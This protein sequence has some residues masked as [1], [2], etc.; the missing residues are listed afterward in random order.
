MNVTETVT[1]QITINDEEEGQRLRDFLQ[2]FAPSETRELMIKYERDR[3]NDLENKADNL[4]GTLHQLATLAE[5]VGAMG[6]PSPEDLS[7]LHQ[8]ACVAHNAVKKYDVSPHKA[9]PF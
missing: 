1:V 9:I 4:R 8:A 7:R 2:S 5:T 6:E 3:D